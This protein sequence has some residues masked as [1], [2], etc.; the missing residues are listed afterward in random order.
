MS[1]DPK[2]IRRH[3]IAEEPTLARTEEQ[4]ALLEASNGLAQFDYGLSVVEDAIAKGHQFRFRP[5]LGLALH[6][7][8]LNG[9]SARAGNWRPAE[10]RIENSQHQPVGAHLVPEQI[11]T[12]CDY[13]NENL[14]AKSPIHLATFA[15]WRLNWIHPF[16]DGNGRTSRIFSYVVLC[17]SLR[18]VLSGTNTIPEQIVHN[19][20]P[21]FD[22]L[23]AA[24]HAFQEGRIDLSKM[25]ALLDSMLAKQLLDLHQR[26]V[27]TPEA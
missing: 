14:I 18:T 17:I 23:E 15:M 27:G 9:L 13:L 5:S 1:N 2:D 7:E 8:A 21:Y 16:T 3:S 11:E 12:M 10:V 4:Q 24:D 19:R 25:E 22:A 26:A 20:M 6:R